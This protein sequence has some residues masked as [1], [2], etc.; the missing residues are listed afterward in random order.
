MICSSTVSKSN[1][2]LGGRK[3]REKFDQVC[4]SISTLLTATK[5]DVSQEEFPQNIQLLFFSP[6]RLSIWGRDHAM[7]H[8][9]AKAQK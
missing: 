9:N 1:D 2:Q 5:S 3:S 4:G 7:Y 8:N 6:N